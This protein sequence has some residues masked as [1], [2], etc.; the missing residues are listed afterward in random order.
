[1]GKIFGPACNQFIQ[2]IL[3]LPAWILVGEFLVL[4]PIRITHHAAKR[5]PFV[6]VTDRDGNPLVVTFTGITAVGRHNFI[7]VSHTGPG[8]AVHHFFHDDFRNQARYSFVLGNIDMLSLAC[9]VAVIQRC[10]YPNQ[11]VHAADRVAGIRSG[12]NRHLAGISKWG[13]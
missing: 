6:I 11:A 1:M 2:F 3:I 4:S 5:F 8:P 13:T 10:Q 9:P 7:A 12:N